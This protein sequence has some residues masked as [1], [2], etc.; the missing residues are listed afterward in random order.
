MDTAPSMTSNPSYTSSERLRIPQSGEV[1]PN[2]TQSRSRAQSLRN[3]DVFGP[4]RASV[5]ST[6][7]T[8]TGEDG[9]PPARTGSIM[10]G[11]LPADDGMRNLREQMHQIR[12]MALSTEEKA[13]RMH[14]LMVADYERF[15]EAHDTSQKNAQ[16]QEPGEADTTYLQLLAPR[17]RSPSPQAGE[18]EELYVTPEDLRITFY[19]CPE[20]EAGME[21]DGEE[22]EPPLGCKHYMRNVKIQCADCKHWYNCRHCHDEVETH[23]LN[24]K[25]TKFM[26]CM[27]CGTAQ[28]A[29]EYCAN[30]GLLTASYYCD[31]CKL[32]DNDADHRIYHCPDC[33]ICRRG[34][35]LG[36]DY[37]HCKVRPK[38]CFS[39]S[40]LT[41]VI[42]LQRLHFD[43]L[44]SFPP[45][46]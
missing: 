1:S 20:G 2:F 46:R 12:E 38:D 30:C 35:G 14:L 4:R 23:A 11:A 21:E 43:F 45:L 18:D 32:W 42:A 10:S 19:P 31:I 17:I 13:R 3:A 41:H 16:A 5:P 24:R 9:N 33:G 6:S 34:E 22:V 37:M 40:Q 28:P 27:P 44:L 39:N 15:R 25:K 7:L 36:N 8:T 29:A 26:L